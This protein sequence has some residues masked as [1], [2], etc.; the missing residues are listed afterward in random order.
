MNKAT[1]GSYVFGLNS[2]LFL[3]TDKNNIFFLL[4]TNKCRIAMHFD[5]E[6]YFYI[7]LGMSS[8]SNKREPFF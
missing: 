8:L 1:I 5:F 7:D 4:E 6:S 2:E 3:H